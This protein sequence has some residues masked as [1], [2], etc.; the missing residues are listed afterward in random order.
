MAVPI[1][2]A[3]YGPRSLTKRYQA[4]V[5][6]HETGSDKTGEKPASSTRRPKSGTAAAAGNTAT[7]EKSAP[8]PEAKGGTAAVKAAAAVSEAAAT[9]MEPLQ[10]N[11]RSA[12]RVWPD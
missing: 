10:D 2:T 8:R 3:F 9:T 6:T 7:T 4:M 5:T 11:Y 12:G 1:V